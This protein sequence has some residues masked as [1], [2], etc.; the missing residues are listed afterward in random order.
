[1]ANARRLIAVVRFIQKETFPW[2]SIR[3]SFRQD[4]WEINAQSALDTAPGKE[5]HVQIESSERSLCP[6]SQITPNVDDIKMPTAAPE[7]AWA[8]VPDAL[9]S[10]FLANAQYVT[11]ELIA[12]ISPNG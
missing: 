7:N 2:K 11:P 6:H 12:G 10:N 1:V 5:H 4:A 3:Y 8:S 9:R